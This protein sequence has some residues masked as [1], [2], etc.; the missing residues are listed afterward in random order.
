VCLHPAYARSNELGVFDAT[1]NEIA[2][3]LAGL[4][5]TPVRAAQSSTGDAVY[6]AGDPPVLRLPDVIVQGTSLQPPAFRAALDTELAL[7]LV[8]EP[9]APPRAATPAQDAV[10]LYLLRRAG[11]TAS[12]RLITADPEVTAASQRL[13]SLSLTSR[14]DWFRARL[15][16]LRSGAIALTEVP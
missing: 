13:L 5:G 8:T 10:A 3:P 2:A 1:V 11:L 6:V 4:P 12:P 9:G 14:A 15:S 7:A 16:A